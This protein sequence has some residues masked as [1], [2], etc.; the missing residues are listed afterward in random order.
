MAGVCVFLA[1]AV[2]AV[3]GQT[4]HFEFINYDDNQYVYENPVVQ[5]GLTW[6]GALWALTYGEIGHWHP[7]TWLTHMA[8]CQV[9][10]LWAGGHHLTNVALHAVTAVLLFLVLR[11]M[12][13]ALWRSALVAA[14]FAVHPLRA[15][16][17]AWIAERKDVLS[18]MFFMLTLWA[19]ARYARRPSRGRYV[20]MALLY[21]MGLLSKNMLV[22][23][24][25]VLLLL[26]W[27]PL[28]RMKGMQ[29]EECRMKNEESRARKT[30]GVTFWGLVREK[31]P[32]LLLSV[33][34]CLVTAY[35]PEQIANLDR[36]PVLERVA[37]ALVSYVVYL[38]QMVFPEN[39]SVPYLFP[40]GGTPLWKACLAFF[41]LAGVTAVAMECRRKRPYLLVGWLW[42][43]GML[44]PV[45]GLAQISYY[46]RADRYTYLPGIGLAIAGIWAVADLSAG[47]RH[48]RLLGSGL[49]TVILVA[50]IFRAHSQT[51]YWRQSELLWTHSLSL[52]PANT[53]ARN[54]LG[55]ALV[56]DGKFDEAIA[57]YRKVLEINPGSAETH[58]DLGGA[59]FSQA[60]I[61]EAVAQYRKALEIEPDFMEARNNLGLAYFTK[62]ETD[63]A[64]AQYRRVLQ[65]KPEVPGV[66]YNLG[67]A[68]VARFNLGNALIKEGKFDEAIAQYRMALEINSDSAKAH[69]GLGMALFS[70]AHMDEAI[71]QYRMALEIEPD[72][73]QARDN[74]GLAYFRKGETDEA[75][76]QY[77]KALESKP[78]DPATHYNLGLALFIKGETDQA[79]AQYRKTLESQPDSAETPFT[80]EARVSLGTALFT[81]G[82]TDEAIAQYRKALQGAPDNAEARNNLG[83]ALSTKGEFKEAMDSWQ[84]SLEINP[85]QIYVLNNLA[86]LLATNPDASLRN[87]ARAVALAAQAS[88]LSGK[89]N[90]TVLH[91]LAAA[92]A[93][94]GSY[95]LAAATARRGLELAMGQ[96][97]DALAAALQREIKLYD[98]G[99]PVRDAAR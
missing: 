99:A 82:E 3:F 55:N 92:Y 68:T 28:G 94:A 89:G 87:G 25:F 1:L 36:K 61:D 50:L 56:K 31:I 27:W 40:P 41:A 47:W 86:W 83:S 43:L 97:N 80:A 20:A 75:I 17:V 77:R 8:D 49:A 2:L 21:G 29:N 5:H 6:K 54:N 90:P 67:L 23:L 19:Y 73:V 95:G 10:G 59:L 51:F 16:S 11:A 96:K 74:L 71:A 30:A 39:L 32:L 66:R 35:V 53:F 45:I 15:E 98:A 13:G 58:N 26:D 72:Y 65:S 14:V 38:Q 84:Q 62:G 57:Q 81:K 12:T 85:N 76:V 42:Y 52:T 33:A 88:Q 79:I 64:I 93:E 69:N 34:I 24:P 91:T 22:T 60:H 18:G 46:A 9:Y 44:V 63:E 70:Q 4:A 37:N 78:G 7:L 48:R